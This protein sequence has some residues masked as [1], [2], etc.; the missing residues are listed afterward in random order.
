MMRTAFAVLAALVLA[1]GFAR[2]DTTRVTKGV[3]DEPPEQP[4]AYFGFGAAAATPVLGGVA[5]EAGIRLGDSSL[6][7]HGTAADLDYFL[8][9]VRAGLEERL[10]S[11]PST[12]CALFGV[13]VGEVD[14]ASLVSPRI[15]F[16]AGTGP[17]HFR[18]TVEAEV[19]DGTFFGFGT[20][21][22][23]AY[24]H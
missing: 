18:P 19:V 13:D 6:W 9:V 16:D 21:L 23:I 3:Y 2:A 8:V 20:T 24:E 11:D 15:G 17:I 10:C 22:T 12:K 7:L 4:H 5:L 1:P 14:G